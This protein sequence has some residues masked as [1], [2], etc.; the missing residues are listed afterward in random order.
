MGHHQHNP[1]VKPAGGRLGP[2]TC[3]RKGCDQVFEPVRW[4]QRYC[5]DAECLRELRRWQ[6]VRRQR[7][8]RQSAANRKR[9]A[10]AQARRRQRARSAMA[11]GRASP[12]DSRKAPATDGAWSRSKAIPGDF[13]SRPGCYEPL[14]SDSRAP[15]RYCGGDC[16]QAVRRVRDRERKWLI[17][18]QYKASHRRWGECGQSRRQVVDR[19]STADNRAAAAIDNSAQKLVGDYRDDDQQRLSSVRF[20]RHQRRRFAEDDDS[21]TNP[22]R[23]SRPPPSR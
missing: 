10:E 8:Y 15:A 17:R 2:R 21:Q 19:P 22:D 11:E 1:T 3:L 14:P 4:N 6:A 5:Q 7:T 18:K 13:C 12:T 20:E 23:R 9:Q 16:R